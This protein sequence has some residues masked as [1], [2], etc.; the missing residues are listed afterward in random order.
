MVSINHGG[1]TSIQLDGTVVMKTSSSPKET[2]GSIT[3]WCSCMLS[4]RQQ[5]WPGTGGMHSLSPALQS[6]CVRD[7]MLY[8]TEADVMAGEPHIPQ[9]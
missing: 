8:L 5:G 6:H 9:W 4:T 2:S 3:H 7:G 1:V